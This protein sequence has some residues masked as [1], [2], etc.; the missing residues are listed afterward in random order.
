M[1]RKQ[2]IL[3]V[4]DHE[5]TRATL[6]DALAREGYIVIPAGTGREAVERTRDEGIDLVL[7]DLRLPDLGD[8][9]GLA[10]L[11]AS[12]KHAPGRPVILITGHGS[13][14]T[15][16]EAM[17]RGAHDYLE[18]PVDLRRLRK[19]AADALRLVRLEGEVAALR[20]RLGGENAL[21]AMVGVSK[22]I[23][24]VKDTIRQVAPTAATVL[25][26]GES[27]TG[28]ELAANAIHAVSGRARGP[29][30]KTHLAAVPKDLVE[31]ELFGHERGAFTGAIRRKIGRFEQAD[32]GTLFLDEIGEM[33][34]ETQIKLLRV[35]ESREFERVGGTETLHTDIRLV[36]AANRDLRELVRAGSFR[37]DLYFRVNV[38]RLNLPPLRERKEDVAVLLAYF[39]A[40]FPDAGGRPREFTERARLA[41]EAYDWPG[42]VRELRNVV[43]R[44]SVL[45][46]GREVDLADLPEEITAA[47][48]ERAAGAAIPSGASMAQ[49][50]E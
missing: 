37:E 28:K 25:V 11:D 16:V 13:V 10:V 6:A 40:Q 18:K 5:T 4:D 20:S 24:R 43:E 48:G 29:L 32:G 36:A 41:L 33:P 7:T 26:Q 27:G 42:N 45:A 12:K 9:G 14:E 31:S 38:V 39:S 1:T 19:M 17:K 3:L 8:E 47:S 30:V 34:S 23:Q 15:A 44:A 2:T 22:A 46:R 49:I 35:L 21:E 50:E